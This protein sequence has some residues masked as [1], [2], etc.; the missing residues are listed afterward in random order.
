[1][2]I[3]DFDYQLPEELIA[4]HPPTI[5][6]TTRLLVLNRDSGAIDDSR[7]A[8]IAHHVSPGDVVV[9]N[10]TRV[11]PARLRTKKLSNGVDR[12]LVLI[13][14]HGS[15]D[16]WH[17]HKVIYR[18]KLSVGD[19][20]ETSSHD[21]ISV[22]QIEGDGIAIVTSQR[23]L[24]DICQEIGEVPLPPYMNRSATSDDT[25]RYQTVWAKYNGSVAAP[26]ASLNM[27]N[28]IID[29]IT[30]AGGIVRY[31]T[32]HVGLGTFMPIRS[33][34]VEDHDIHQEYFEIPVDTITSIRQAK[35]SGHKIIAVGTT[36]TRTL[37]YAAESILTGTP[38]PIR[39]EANIYIYP[40]YTFKIVDKLLTNFHAPRSTVL[41]LTAAF[42]GWNNLR[43]AYLHAVQQK[44][45]FFSYGDSMLITTGKKQS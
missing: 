42:A 8:D 12:E 19:Q 38:E 36:V 31:L 15:N 7:Y 24:L 37:E 43:N 27:T 41:M 13:E 10:D 28:E 34:N 39:G 45:A 33:E 21:I 3:S 32:L 1:M 18:G 23:S 22:E 40:G 25:E 4:D 16:D 30:A 17:R 29:S 14:Q 35:A 20:L 44:Y 9:L 26:T 5:R 6:G 11:I 2:K